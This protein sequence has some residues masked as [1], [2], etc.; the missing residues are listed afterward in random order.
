MI[1]KYFFKR[2]NHFK[3][4]TKCSDLFIQTYFI[5]LYEKLFSWKSW[6]VYGHHEIH[7]SDPAYSRCD[8]WGDYILNLTFVSS[9]SFVIWSWGM[10]PS[11]LCHGQI[12][13]QGSTTLQELTCHKNLKG[14]TVFLKLF[15]DILNFW[16]TVWL[17]L[18][19]PPGMWWWQQP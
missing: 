9:S 14:S 11:V 13:T 18:W 8:Q 1:A 3:I 19:S 15:H 4:E 2:M 7:D 10:L 5:I 12:T 6:L 16:Y 17:S